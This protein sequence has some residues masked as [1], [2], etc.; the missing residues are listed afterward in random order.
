MTKLNTFFGLLGVWCTLALHGACPWEMRLTFT[1]E[2]ELFSVN[3][4]IS[5]AREN[6]SSLKSLHYLTE[7]LHRKEGVPIAGYLPQ[8]L[9]EGAF[10]QSSYPRLM[11][12]GISVTFTQLILSMAGPVEQLRIA[13]RATKIAGLQELLQF[14]AIHYDT[15]RNFFDL[16]ALEEKSDAIRSYD[17]AVSI[18]FDRAAA[19]YEVDFLSENDWLFAKAAYAQNVASIQTYTQDVAIAANTL[20]RTIE[21]RLPAKNF[22]DASLEKYVHDAR[23]NLKPLEHYLAA[24]AGNRK[25]L[26]I[27]TEEIKQERANKQLYDRGYIPTV[28]AYLNITRGGAA[29]TQFASQAVASG[30]SQEPVWEAGILLAW[31]FDGLQNVHQSSAEA[32]LIVSKKMEKQNLSYQVDLDV[33][34]A[35]ERVLQKLE[36]LPAQEEQ[37]KQASIDYEKEKLNYAIGNT[38]DADIMNAEYQWKQAQF[39]LLEVKKTLAQAYSALLFAC[40]YPELY[41]S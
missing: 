26:M 23:C 7:S 12:S 30:L 35:Y 15:E 41:H 22:S 29:I 25:E 21:T 33:K 31:E 1:N 32:S 28:S 2:K 39:A 13:Q 16:Y 38:S 18:S 4:A 20:E 40:G 37:F 3:S 14:D 11:H 17:F 8:I 34:N 19:A 27:K 10:S 24:G 5:L 36:L 9:F 6:R